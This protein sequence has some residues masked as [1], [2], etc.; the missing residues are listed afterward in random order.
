MTQKA[1]KA[2]A[3]DFFKNPG[4]KKILSDP[5]RCAKIQENV[6]I[7]QLAAEIEKL[8]RTKGISQ[9][10][11]AEKVKISQQE[12]SRIERGKRNI[13]IDT[14]FKI[15]SGFDMMPVIKFVKNKECQI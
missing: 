8:R 12:L 1:R 10:E 2:K 14:L 9:K 6:L 5:K 15:S 3:R 7:F 13:T 4:I 11:L